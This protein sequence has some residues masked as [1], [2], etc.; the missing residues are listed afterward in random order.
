MSSFTPEVAQALLQV[1]LTS[2]T[3]ERPVTRAVIAAIPPDKGDYTPDPITRSAIELAWHIVMAENRFLE[4]VL[5]SVF[6]LTPRPRP[7]TITTAAQVNAWYDERLPG[8]LE[9]LKTVSGEDLTKLIDFR[10]IMKFPA[11]VFLRIGLNHTVHHRG[12]LSMYLRPMGA[13]VPSIYGESYDART[14][15]EA[16][17]AGR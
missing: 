8:L 4:A 11:V 5:N 6:D 2:I 1:E 14:A 12:Q 10:G 7:E 16:R 3:A 9:R 17:E 13:A 15:R